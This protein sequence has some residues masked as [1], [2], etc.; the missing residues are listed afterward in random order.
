MLLLNEVDLALGG[1]VSKSTGS[2]G[3]FA[4]F[5]SEGALASHPD[6]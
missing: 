6:L 2:F 3:I 1:G 5:K 4:G